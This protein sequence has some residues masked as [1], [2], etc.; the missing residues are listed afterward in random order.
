MTRNNLIWKSLTFRK[1]ANELKI[2]EQ[3]GYIVRIMDEIDTKVTGGMKEHRA[4]YIHK[5]NLE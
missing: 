4:V 3:E 5:H 1:S 2:H